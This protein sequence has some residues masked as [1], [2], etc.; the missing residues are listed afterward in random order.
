VPQLLPDRPDWAEAGLAVWRPGRPA[1]MLSARPVGDTGVLA[2]RCIA[3]KI[4]CPRPEMK[5][6][7]GDYH[8]AAALASAFLR[9]GVQARIDFA[10][11]PDRHARPDDINIVLRGRHHFRPKRGAI[12]LMW[13]ISHPDRP[14]IDEMRGFD[15]IFIASEVWTRQIA[16][17]SGL[18]CQTLLQ[19]TDSARFY[20]T[21]PD[22]ALHSPALFVANSRNVLRSVVREAVEQHLP[23]DI[24][25]EM[26]E[27]LAPAEWIRAEKI[28]NVELPRYYASADVVLNDHWDSMRANGF[29]SNRIFDVLACATP[30]VTDRIAGLPEEIAACCHFFG[31]GVLLAEAVAAARRDANRAQALRIAEL[32]RRDHSFDA[33]C[34]DI[35]AAILAKCAGKYAAR[36]LAG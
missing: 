28:E 12:N 35:I 2:G 17:E 3:L 25:G 27:G 1:T 16:R 29:V 15:H 34:D 9:K 26:W 19:C 31:D 30:L 32:V 10:A 14:S 22:P 8:F 20:P 24:Y 21:E 23:I 36:R 5:D 33:R 11:E 4:G 13:L 18:A 7:W 6:N